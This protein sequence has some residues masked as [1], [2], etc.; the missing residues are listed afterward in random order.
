V[1]K[2]DTE[3]IEVDHVEEDTII[4]VKVKEAHKEVEDIT[5]ISMS[6]RLMKSKKKLKTLLKNLT[7]MKE[8]TKKV[9]MEV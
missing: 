7:M 4:E 2:M 9:I 8:I 6:Q 5:T 3:A 1:E